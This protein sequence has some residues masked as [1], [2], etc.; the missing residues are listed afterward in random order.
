MAFGFLFVVII[1]PW[2]VVAADRF[3]EVSR[4]ADAVE[5]YPLLVTF[6]R[7]ESGVRAFG[8][9]VVL[10]LAELPNIRRL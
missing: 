5:L 9:N 10:Q 4:L 2:Y 6:D 7:L 3:N 8:Q 1:S